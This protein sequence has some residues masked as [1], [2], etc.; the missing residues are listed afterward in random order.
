MVSMTAAEFALTGGGGATVDRAGRTARVMLPSSGPQADL[1]H[2]A[3]A[4]IASVFSWWDGRETFHAA[5]FALDG[6]AW[7]VAG[8]KEAG[9]TS[10]MARLAQEHHSILSDDMVVVDGC[11]T[12]AGPRCLDLRPGSRSA[13]GSLEAFASRA[14]ERER[15]VL[16]G[17]APSFAFRGWVFLEWGDRLEI[18][19]IPVAERIRRLAGIRM[20]TLPPHDPCTLVELAALPAWRLVRP[21]DWGAMD[22]A[23]AHLLDIATS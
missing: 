7:A 17:V 5:G 23:V 3:L 19:R 15:V 22:G 13:R 21:R 20:W 4:R 11:T 1:V 9:K 6:Q 2:P 8:E 18:A 12:F 14:G 16:A 10:L